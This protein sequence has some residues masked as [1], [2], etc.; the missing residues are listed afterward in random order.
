ME[1]LEFNKADILAVAKAVQY[2]LKSE[3]QAIIDYTSLIDIIS[4]STMEQQ[5]K[6]N[7]LNIISELVADELN[8]EQKLSVL[9]SALTGIEAKKD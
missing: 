5:E 8:H 7:A 1:D 6:D 2:N 9:Y 4:N 3:G